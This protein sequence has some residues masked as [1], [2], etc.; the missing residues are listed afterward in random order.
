MTEHVKKPFCTR[1]LLEELDDE[2]IYETVQRTIRSI[3]E[4]KRTGE[5]EYR[6]RLNGCKECEK[7]V[8]GMCRVCGCF[9]EVRA[10]YVR[11]KCPD[12]HPRW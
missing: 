11:K 6:K 4:E 8:Q 3:P 10:A 9:V 7:L 2:T 1:C 12:I 5:T